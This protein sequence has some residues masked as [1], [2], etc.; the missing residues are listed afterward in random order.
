M[1]DVWLVFCQLVPFAEVILLTAQEY[2]RVE[3]PK[4]EEDDAPKTGD[5]D[6]EQATLVQVAVND[7][8]AAK[9]AAEDNNSAAVVLVEKDHKNLLNKRQAQLKIIGEFL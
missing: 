1:I 5:Q 8:L 6:I 2:Y 4:E 3:D 7:V 9:E